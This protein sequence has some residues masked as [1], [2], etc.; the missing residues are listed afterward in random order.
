MKGNK[1]MDEIRELKAQAYDH[2]ASIEFHQGQ[3][4]LVNKKISEL[5]QKSA[6]PNLPL[7]ENKDE[8]AN[9]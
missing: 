2:L 3:L 6:G 4:Q 7:G 1:T 5:S 9:N 8:K